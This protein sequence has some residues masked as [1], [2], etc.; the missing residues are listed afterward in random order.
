MKGMDHIRT[1]RVNGE[2]KPMWPCMRWHKEFTVNFGENLQGQCEVPKL[3]NVKQI[4]AGKR[5]VGGIKK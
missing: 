1:G 4:S 2:S 5:S 3:D